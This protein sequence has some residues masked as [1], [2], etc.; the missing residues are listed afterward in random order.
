M[1]I[2]PVLKK[3]DEKR[4]LFQYFTYFVEPI[5]TREYITSLSM[6]SL[7]SI[8][9][10]Y[11]LLQEKQTTTRVIGKIMTCAITLTAGLPLYQ[12]MAHTLRWWYGNN[13]IHPLHNSCLG[14][15]LHA[16]NNIA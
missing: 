16:L 6:A 10:A 8:G 15:L 9:A 7:C 3:Q 14:T 5:G 1:R 4:I 12:T 2:L 11:R 13:T